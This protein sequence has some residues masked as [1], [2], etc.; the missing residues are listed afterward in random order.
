MNT[1]ELPHWFPGADIDAVHEEERWRRY[2]AR[3]AAWMNDNPGALPCEI[4]HFCA[5]VAEEL[6]L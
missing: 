6:G 4:Q 2:E 5:V 3:K 1:A